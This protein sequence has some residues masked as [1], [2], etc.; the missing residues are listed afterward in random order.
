MIE[1][2][3]VPSDT[4]AQIKEDI[5]DKEG[6]PLENQHLFYSGKRLD[7]D[8]RLADYNI[9]DESV[10]KLKVGQI[11]KIFVETHSGEKLELEVLP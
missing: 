4:V 7:D 9:H 11:M 8:K 10:L 6:V 1:L 3:V 5:K 2:D